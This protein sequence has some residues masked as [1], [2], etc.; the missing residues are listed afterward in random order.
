MAIAAEAGRLRGTEAALLA[1]LTNATGVEGFAI[2]EN[3]PDQYR[4]A[5]L[6]HIRVTVPAAAAAQLDIVRRLVSGERPAWVTF[7]LSVV[8]GA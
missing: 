6:F 2:D 8:G 5:R 7:E 1:V 3:L 4:R